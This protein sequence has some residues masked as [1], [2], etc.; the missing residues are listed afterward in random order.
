MHY[1]KLL[2]V[3]WLVYLIDEKKEKEA[4]DGPFL[5]KYFGTPMQ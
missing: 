1:D 3:M 4:S 5:K 2:L